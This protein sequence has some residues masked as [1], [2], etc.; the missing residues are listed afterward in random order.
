METPDREKKTGSGYDLDISPAPNDSREN[1]LKY[2]ETEVF[3]A[4][5]DGVNFRTVGWIRGT[6]IAKIIFENDAD[7]MTA[8]MFFTKVP[9]QRRMILHFLNSGR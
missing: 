5:E 3:S 7:Q 4:S 8:A 1:S 2:G 9:N 6:F